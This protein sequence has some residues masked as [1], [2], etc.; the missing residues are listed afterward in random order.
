MRAAAFFDMLSEKQ[1]R[2]THLALPGCVLGTAGW[3]KLANL[4]VSPASN[5]HNLDISKTCLHDR[6][7][8][9]ISNALIKNNTLR[10]L[11]LHWH[12]RNH[13][14]TKNGWRIFSG[15]ISHP[16]CTLE[17]LHLGGNDLCDKSAAHLGDALAV[18]R[19]VT[20]LDLSC[21]RTITLQ[22]WWKFSKCLRSATCVLEK[23]Y[24][25]EWSIT[26]DMAAVI[27]WSLKRN[28]CLKLLSVQ[29]DFVTIKVW[30]VL[31]HILCDR[32]TIDTCYSS[33]HTLTKLR[34]SSHYHWF[35]RD[36]NILWSSL[37]YLKI[38]KLADKA[39]VARKKI[40]L[41]HFSGE[42]TSE[43]HGFTCMDETILPFALEWI[44]RNNDGYSLMFNVVRGLPSLFGTT[45]II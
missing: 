28:N 41:R 10:T 42:R 13:P 35:G 26:D 9:I 34:V 25:D 6:S 8:A 40:M 21:Q 16:M 18:N 4:L 38:N 39:V 27:V 45:C 15:V 31:A 30:S 11:R 32:S 3:T 37:P 12:Y 29:E 2:V 1:H 14:L 43:I 19:T 44:G 24:L 5:I 36:S 33:N 17:D 23:L 7:I 20:R 22:G